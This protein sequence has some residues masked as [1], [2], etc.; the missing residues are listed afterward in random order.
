MKIRN[1]NSQPSKTTTGHSHLPD[2]EEIHSE[3][4]F[5]PR[6]HHDDNDQT[7]LTP[8][9]QKTIPTIAY[10]L[11]KWLNKSQIKKKKLKKQ[12]SAKNLVGEFNKAAKENSKPP[13]K[14]KPATKKED[15]SVTQCKR[16]IKEFKREADYHLEKYQLLLKNLQLETRKLSNM[17]STSAPRPASVQPPP[18]PPP[19]NQPKPKS[20]WIQRSTP[21]QKQPLVQNSFRTG[22]YHPNVI[23]SQHRMM[24]SNPD[25]WQ[26]QLCQIQYQPKVNN[27]SAQPFQQRQSHTPRQP[28]PP[29]P[30]AQSHLQP[31]R[32]C[33][34]QGWNNT[35]IAAK[36]AQVD[37]QTNDNLEGL[38]HLAA[39]SSQS[40]PTP[41]PRFNVAQNRAPLSLSTAINFLHTNLQKKTCCQRSESFAFD[42][43]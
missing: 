8:N 22:Y 15:H 18:L 40:R 13:A 11:N 33:I 27:W 2:Y 36:A 26:P 10:H 39:A 42:K 16:R 20:Q 38:M 41:K 14:T 3:T 30:A 35:K 7:L 6:D 23:N 29:K 1:I 43:F 17:R 4:D 12:L 37:A 28:L 19:R 32:N 31:H 21:Q 25:L 9:D 34:P 24:E 5:D